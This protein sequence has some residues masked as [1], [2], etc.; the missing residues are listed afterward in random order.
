MTCPR[1]GAEMTR[2]AP[3][4]EEYDIQWECHRCGR[5]ILEPTRPLEE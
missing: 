3:H 4:G 1:C 5:I 2:G